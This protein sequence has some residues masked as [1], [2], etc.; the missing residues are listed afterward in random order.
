MQ[1]FFC[2]LKAHMICLACACCV[3]PAH[4][5]CRLSTCHFAQGLTSTRI[6]ISYFILLIVRL[7]KQFFLSINRSWVLHR[8]ADGTATP[9]FWGYLVPDGL[10][11]V[12]SELV[13]NAQIA[14][15]FDLDETLLLANTAASLREKAAEAVAKRAALEANIAT[16]TAAGGSA[17]L[18][19]AV[20]DTRGI[21]MHSDQSLRPKLRSQS[22]LFVSACSRRC[23]SVESLTG[24]FG[25]S[26]CDAHVQR[27]AQPGAL[28]RRFCDVGIQII[29]NVFGRR[30]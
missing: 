23:H 29:L 30:H 2:V 6:T 24:I 17:L 21:A 16:K 13:L 9:V 18:P 11:S 27:Q 28:T 14:V 4:C 25:T 10:V 15:V 12:A 8:A 1:S 7:S 3:F 22:Q 20:A 5:L 19:L 26:L